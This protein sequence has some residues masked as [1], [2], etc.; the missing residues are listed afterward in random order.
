MVSAEE[1][2]QRAEKRRQRILAKSAQRLDAVSHGMASKE[3]E[4]TVPLFPA[5]RRNN[6]TRKKNEAGSSTTDGDGNDN[7]IKQS[8]IKNDESSSAGA[9]DI[10]MSS[11]K[12]GK[13]PMD[14]SIIKTATTTTTTTT[15]GTAT[16]TSSYTATPTTN[17]A[18]SKD[19]GKS[20]MTSSTINSAAS[21]NKKTYYVNFLST[22]EEMIRQQDY[23][24][25]VTTK[26]L[27]GVFD[28]VQYLG[29]HSSSSGGGGGNV[30][31]KTAP[32]QDDGRGG[33]AKQRIMLTY[34]QI[35]RC[36]LRMNIPWNRSLPP[37]STDDEVSVN[38]FNSFSAASGVSSGNPFSAV[39]R[40]RD[41]IT[42]DAQLI[43]LLTAL[44]E[45]EER[46]RAEQMANNEE[47][48]DDDDVERRGISFPEFVQCYQLIV[49]GMQSLQILDV[50][51]DDSI[52]AQIVD[53]VTERTFGL[54]RPFG[55]DA[56]LY[57]EGSAGEGTAT[58]AAAK[59]GGGGGG[60]DDGLL[61]SS[62]RAGLSAK[63]KSMRGNDTKGGLGENEIQSLIQSKDS[64]IAMLIHEH[65]QEMDVLE[66]GMESLRSKH[67]RTRKLMKLRRGLLLVGATILG[68]AVITFV[69][70][71][72]H[73]WRVDVADGISAVREAERKANA[74]TIAK[75]S[76]KRDVLG[77]KV[78]DTE[79]TMRYLVNRNEGIDASI[80]E[81]EA[82]MERVDMKYFIRMAD[83]QRC[84]VQ[85]KELG[86]AL[87]EESI[88]MKE[89]NE[90][91][92]WCQSRSHF[93]EK[94][95][96]TL[97]HADTDQR[98]KDDDS[99]LT[100]D[101][102]LNL[103]MKYNK[104]TRHAVT[105]RQAYSAAAGLV[106][107]TMIHQLLPFA[108]KLFAPKPVQVITEVV[109]APARRRFP[110]WRRNKRTELAVVDGIFG[111]SISYL[112]IRAIALFILP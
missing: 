9:K 2:R 17:D 76:E 38:S 79:G 10:M 77:R 52:K 78:G 70:T 55:P 85:Q 69:N 46:Y 57:K 99:G 74:K 71:R 97:E 51:G 87:T 106:V 94:E 6:Q 75:L 31:N 24:Y 72:E 19:G 88:K 49:A 37:S 93:M 96:N 3:A 30:R 45:A 5:R 95:L 18:A 42:T 34:S 59:G 90:E 44:V 23:E 89:M 26:H 73:Q 80:K 83:L 35:R 29:R 112:L 32:P 33:T 61:P 60:A 56:M 22:Y 54:I 58:G 25:D 91:L 109:E 102:A 1:A 36:L 65:E 11:N 47:E 4:N 48:D 41:V 39:G 20:T 43:M 68:V 15:S 63:G 98:D 28:R 100:G 108:I 64:R 21:S 66:K 104:S 53:R 16:T 107:S 103:D 50:G 101:Q 111:S 84:V 92:G 62:K 27:Q 67:V 110:W 12:T 81:L 40:K 82:E 13:P 7:T 14:P 8:E 86:E 105:V